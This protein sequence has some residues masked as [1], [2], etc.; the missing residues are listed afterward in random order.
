LTSVACR[1]SGGE[2]ETSEH[3]MSTHKSA[4]NV[5][6]CSRQSADT[7]ETKLLPKANGRFVGGDDEI[8]LHDG[9]STASFST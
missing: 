4:L 6:K 2:F 9:S 1:V 5:T 3:D 7:H 8:E